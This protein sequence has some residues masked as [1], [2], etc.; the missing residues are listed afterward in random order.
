MSTT[1]V[2]QQTQLSRFNMEVVLRKVLIAASQVVLV[3]LTYF[4]SFGLR[5]DFAP[6][7]AMRVV[8]WKSIAV[9]I[10]VKLAG[11][12]CF[13]LLR[14]WWRYAGMSDL[15]DI[16]KAALTTS[17]VL[18][19]ILVVALPG[20]EFPRSVIMI[21]C[22]LT[23]LSLGGARFG[24][25]AY[26]ETIERQAGK[27]RTLIIGTGP[28]AISMVRELR[29]NPGVDYSPVA[30]IDDDPTKTGI[31]IH[32]V[33]VVGT[34][35]YL[36]EAIERYGV[37]CVLIAKHGSHSHQIH[38]A[39]VERCQNSKVEFKLLPAFGDWIK[40]GNSIAQLRT[41]NVE[42]LLGRPPVRLDKS[43]IRA[44]LEDKVVLITGAAGS[45]GSELV[46]QVAK[47]K[48]KRIILYDRSENDQFK[49]SLELSRVFPDLEYVTIVGDVLDVGLLR[50]VFSL[51]RPDSVFHAAAYK[52]VPMMENNCFQAVTNNIFGTYNVA[53]VARQ[54]SAQD[55]VLVSTDKAVNPTNVM[56]VT[57]RICELIVLSLQQQRTKFVAVRFGN[58]LGSNGSVL[59]IFEQQI[60]QGGPI[61]VTHPEATRYFMTIP[62]AAQLV[63]QA[64]TM[65]NGGEIFVLEMGEPVKIVDLAENVIRLSGLQPNTDIKIEF[66][67]L[68][69]GEKLYEELALEAEGT[70]LTSHEKIRVL[71]GG[72]VDFQ[73]VGVW[74]DE[75]N[76]LVL[77]KNM[78][79]LIKKFKNMVPEYKPS[80]QVLARCEVDCHDFVLHHGMSRAF[81]MRATDEHAN[82]KRAR[83]GA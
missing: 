23:I 11:F 75:L 35:D 80:A 17:A 22:F 36:T 74:L 20:L 37:N 61:T 3:A 55:F 48:P 9:V 73:Q 57:K 53:L 67:G 49:L 25:R 58:V 10:L 43:A 76:A 31:K 68:R 1:V 42:D 32:G 46:R 63:L 59:P 5:F 12:A 27:K 33:K 41:V 60:K 66:T 83:S 16:A 18:Y 19:L 79:G 14:G 52:H 29:Q 15:V 62:E 77:A 21:D 82:A 45:I 72:F 44:K 2:Q 65:G 4:A 70:K 71:D 78:G 69:P 30:I 39:I 13:G 47:F 56:G 24:V 26:T 51:Y 38:R 8:L 7:P 81:L 64:S 54:F 6:E 40:G 28:E 50:E 34:I